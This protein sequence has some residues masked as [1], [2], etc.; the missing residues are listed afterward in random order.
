MT[1]KAPIDIAPEEFRRLGH[2]LVDRIAE[3]LASMPQGLVKPD[4]TGETHGFS[5]GVYPVCL[6]G[7]ADPRCFPARPTPGL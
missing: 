4:E 7:T 6:D 5:L 3:H 1:R 2:R